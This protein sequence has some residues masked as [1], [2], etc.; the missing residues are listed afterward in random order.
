MACCGPKL[1]TCCTL[2]SLW[3]VI[4]LL[5]LGFLLKMQ[6]IAFVEDLGIKESGEVNKTT[7]LAEIKEKYDIS[8]SDCGSNLNN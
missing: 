1:S 4:M 3:G 5:I 6:S 8:V 2:L 7:L